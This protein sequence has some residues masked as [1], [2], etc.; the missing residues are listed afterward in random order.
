MKSKTD[1]QLI[2]L[3]SQ[4]HDKAFEELF[5][6]YAGVFLGYAMSILKDQSMAE[7]IV[8]ETWMKIVKLSASYR[9]KG[10]FV[11]WS[12]TMIR[13]QCLN[14]LKNKN[15][16]QREDLNDI[17]EA[18]HVDLSDFE[19]ALILEENKVLL[20]KAFFELPQMQRVC[21]SMWLNEEFSY[22]EIA[23]KLEITLGSVKT[24]LFRAK[25]NLRNQLKG[26]KS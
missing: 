1:D 22:E 7:D 25:E 14:L 15:V 3:I 24:H 17:T 6:R 2:E 20:K 8:Q 19:S 11:A 21:L 10:H 12:Y 4:G 18:N 26:Y 23:E 9:A 16:S 13:N 5:Q